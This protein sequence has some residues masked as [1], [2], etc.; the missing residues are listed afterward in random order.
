[1][2]KIIAVASAL[3]LM[4][5]SVHTVYAA[6]GTENNDDSLK[7][8]VLEA[9]YLLEKVI[10]EQYE[11]TLEDIKE[12]IRE[13]GYDYPSTM[14]SFLDK[15]SPFNNMDYTGILAAVAA[16]NAELEETGNEPVSITDI[17][18]MSWEKEEKTFTE[19]TAV[20]IEDYTEKEDGTYEKSGFHFT[21][22]TEETGIYEEI[23]DSGY[24]KKTGV[25]TIE[26][27]EK[28]KR[29]AKITFTVLS[30]EDVIEA[31]GIDSTGLED[32]VARRSGILAK[33]ISNETLNSSVFIDIPSTLGSK[34]TWLQKFLSAVGY[35]ENNIICITGETIAGIASTLM[36]MVPYEWGGKA[37]SPGYD[38][39]WWLYDTL[40]GN[41][42]GLDCSGFVQWAY[43][44]AGFDNSVTSKLT[45][46]ETMLASD[47]TEVEESELLP[48]DIG[49]VEHA[50][51]NHCGIYAGDGQWYHCSS[52]NNTVVKTEYN[53]TRFFRIIDDSEKPVEKSINI[54]YPDVV[55]SAD[56]AEGNIRNSNEKDVVS[57]VDTYTDI[58]YTFDDENEI[59]Y[60]SDD[61]YLLAQLIYHE[62]NNQG[63]NGWIAVAEVVKN[64]VLN[65]DFP[66]TIRDVIFQ[67]GQF[68]ASDEI[69]SIR[70]KQ[71]QI[72]VAK[73][74]LAGSLGILENSNVLYFRNAKGSTDDWGI[75]RYF[76][77]IGAHQFYLG[78]EN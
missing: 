40:S 2:K 73:N 38:N 32:E 56:K 61:T 45:S 47:M 50:D 62:A 25:T 67:Q 36:G 34:N 52:Y 17:P 8:T 55:D 63:L 44:T 19:R 41:Q 24:Y 28:E 76:T 18:F 49:V 27:D 16:V 33:A 10:K 15:G 21:T 35:E 43:M 58:S 71:E 51:T 64:R 13:E 1:M 70:P 26:P 20:K 74:V 9:T 39:R 31:A 23:E 12:M 22:K 65:S 30:A 59:S 5:S 11:N 6:P 42:N 3:I 7:N 46:T 57:T 37:T 29:Y 72:D 4:T 75:F 69:T 14:E 54:T 68:Q 66:D 78:K 60:V 48:G 77:T 53:F